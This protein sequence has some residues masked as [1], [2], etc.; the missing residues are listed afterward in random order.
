MNR[1]II[2]GGCG[3][4]K[5]YLAKQISDT[6]KIP[7]YD[8]DKVT[9]NKKFTGK[10]SDSLRDKRLRG[11]IKNKSWVIEGTY[12]GDWINPAIR[13]S[14]FI[15]ILKINPFIATKRVIFRFIKRKIRKKEAKGWHITDLPRIMKYAYGYVYD[16]YPKHIKLAKDFDKEYVILKNKKQINSFINNLKCKS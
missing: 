4:G 11:I 14:D 6:T 7:F 1:I 3:H 2:W 9:F 10:V 13:K 15:I 5:T 8:L 16:Y 12:A